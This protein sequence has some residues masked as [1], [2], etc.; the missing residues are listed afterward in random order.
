MAQTIA[1][2][3][4]TPRHEL[5]DD[6]FALFAASSTST[7]S[8]LTIDT[9]LIGPAGHRRQSVASSA[10]SSGFDFFSS[11]SGSRA[12]PSTPLS[13]DCINI[14]ST[15]DSLMYV[16]TEFDPQSTYNSWNEDS[17]SADAMW[18]SLE[19][20]C[21]N[22][23]PFLDCST[24]DTDEIHDPFPGSSTSVGWHLLP[25]S[26]ANPSFSRDIFGE[27]QGPSDGYL[28][29]SG[30]QWILG[31]VQ[32]P[33]QTVAPSATFQPILASSPCKLAPMTPPRYPASATTILSSSPCP[34][35]SPAQLSSEHKYEMAEQLLE[36]TPRTP[37]HAPKARRAGGRSGRHAYDR[38]CTNSSGR[39]HSGVSK[40]GMG[41]DV[42]IETNKYPCDYA[43]CVDKNGKRKMFKRREHAKRHLDTVHLKT[44]QYRCWVS[45]CTTSPFTRS[46][47]LTTHL[48][49]THGKKSASSRNRYV[50]T[51]DPA[52]DY[53]DPEFRGSLDDNGR[54]VDN[55][56][57]LLVPLVSRL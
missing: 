18:M 6:D 25:S 42:V 10:V 11:T 34:L 22:S 9:S 45:G 1:A 2:T 21:R 20:K 48:K 5:D 52:S 37:K 30:S 8:F 56:G 44:R 13:A 26:A 23:V 43:D 14:I 54:P 15:C 12:S 38:R 47:N 39:I 35:Y 46:D 53:F 41:C 3:Q 36:A 50:S 27:R 24:I 16:P 51:L 28:G 7:S 40:S 29:E 32:T 19:T 17:Q 33:P 4:M 49:S 55:S 57:N 31:T